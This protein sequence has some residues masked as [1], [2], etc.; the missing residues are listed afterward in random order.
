MNNTSALVDGNLLRRPAYCLWIVLSIVNFHASIL[1]IYGLIRWKIGTKFLRLF[2]S[3]EL[4]SECVLFLLLKRCLDA[5]I[6]F[7]DCITGQRQ[8]ILKNVSSGLTSKVM[9]SS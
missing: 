3:G 9:F 2:L 5:I 4:A 8:I 1:T 6:R 7:T